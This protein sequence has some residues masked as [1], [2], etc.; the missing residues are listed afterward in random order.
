MARGGRREGTP[1]KGFG[2]RTDLAQNYA[3]MEGNTVATGG[4]PPGA[5]APPPRGRGS[6][7]DDTPMLTSPTGRPE[8]PI[9]AGL[10]TGP[11]P[12]QEA[13]TGF[14]PRA[15]ET[16]MI[17]KKWGPLLKPMADDPET[18]D[19]VRTLIRYLRGF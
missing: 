11:G 4:N 9:T 8:E 5:S 17:A 10:P 6:S 15:E 2:N 16:A 1:G 12:G 13:L 14:D 7:P 18:P 19:S 3:P